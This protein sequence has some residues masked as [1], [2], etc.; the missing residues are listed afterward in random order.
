MIRVVKM[1]SGYYGLE[2][3]SIRKDEENIEEFVSGGEP[4]IIVSS[5]DDL[6]AF[7]IA[8]EDVKMVKK[9]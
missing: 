4:V 7:G 6:N 2:I 5:L 1:G 8:E 9:D 3:D